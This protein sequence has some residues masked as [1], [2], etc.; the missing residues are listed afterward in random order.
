MQESCDPTPAPAL[1][2][3]EA[4]G[5]GLFKC[6]EELF[7]RPE[8]T[9]TLFRPLSAASRWTALSSL[10]QVG[11]R[12]SLCGARPPLSTVL[13]PGPH[14]GLDG[15]APGAPASR[16]SHL[17]PLCPGL[18]ALHQAFSLPWAPLALVSRPH[19][20]STDRLE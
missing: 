13:K 18:A 16:L 4:R 5:G 15:H 3:G 20:G 6:P 12:A 11:G 19:M 8:D 1:E 7:L 10:S 17:R 9:V 2:T 14:V